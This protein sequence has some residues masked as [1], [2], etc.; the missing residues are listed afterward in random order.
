MKASRDLVSARVVVHRVEA[1]A[2]GSVADEG[3]SEGG[4]G[5]A[6]R[7]RLVAVGMGRDFSLAKNATRRRSR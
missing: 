2:W 1:A 5:C 7:T 6:V 3:M 4:G